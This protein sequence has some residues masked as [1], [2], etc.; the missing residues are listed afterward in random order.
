MTVPA[1]RRKRFGR[2]LKI[3]ALPFYLFLAALFYLPQILGL[4]AFPAGDFDEHFLPFNLFL[5][6]EILAG[7]LPVWNSFTYGGHPFL[8]DVQAAVFYPVSDLIL[9]LTLPFGSPAGRLYFLE[10]EAALHLALAGTFTYL[11]VHALTGRRTAALL[12]GCV[13]AFSGY[14]TGYPPLQLAILRTAVWLPLILWLL[15]RAFGGAG[16]AA[17]SGRNAEEGEPRRMI[18]RWRWTVYAGLALTTA[19]LAGHPQTFLFVSYAVA[20]WIV[21]LVGRRLSGRTDPPAVVLRRDLPQVLLFG[22]VFLILSAAQM[23]PS[24]EFTGLS[25]RANVDFAFVSGGFPISDTWQMLIPNVLTTFSPLYIGI[26]ALGLA[27][28]ALAR[29]AR[30]AGR[31]GRPVAFVSFFALLTVVALLISYG[32]NAFL[33]AFFYRWLP[34]WNL[35]RGQERAAYLVAFGGSVLAGYGAA[36]IEAALDRG[37]LRRWGLALAACATVSVVVFA[38]ARALTGHVDVPLAV[39]WRS[40]GLGLV[41]VY[42]AAALLLLPLRR[43]TVARALVILVSLDLFIANDHTNLGNQSLAGQ[44][45]TAPEI[46]AVQTAVTEADPAGQGLPGRT[47]NEYRVYDDYGM[48][49]GVEETG[50]SSPLLLAH[51]AA[52]LRDFPHERFWQLT[53]V[54]HV[55]TWAR[56]LNV[57]SQVLAQFPKGK[58]TTYLH[59]LSQPGARAWI[60]PAAQETDDLTARGLLAS[61]DFDIRQTVLIAGDQPVAGLTPYS[62]GADRVVLS[63]PA[64]AHYQIQVQSEHGG[65]LVV[66]ENWLPGWQATLHPAGGAAAVL[67]VRRGDVA[68]LAIPVPAGEGIVDLAYRPASVRNGLAISAAGA[69]L[70][71]AWSPAAGLL[72]RRRAGRPSRPERK[73]FS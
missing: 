69:L 34:G 37:T 15:Y 23:W 64:P 39:F 33:Y 66:A 43:S 17:L 48:M 29:A 22:G 2:D 24:L 28:L 45:R 12:A 68:F 51:Y 61:D 8:A 16:D 41:L 9:A 73:G 11:L 1:V 46:A 62:P 50:G 71:L 40:A 20:G 4:R 18:S 7:R 5:R 38:L 44:S 10:L 53:G 27:V 49:A 65:W 47:Y 63:R 13:F 30:T 54:Q 56:E 19:F 26:I 21:L 52:L 59:R 42:A 70:L 14:L 72:R 35:F 32:H 6:S 58:E 60:V 36:E 3:A 25:V 57:G 67:P 31:A 55:L